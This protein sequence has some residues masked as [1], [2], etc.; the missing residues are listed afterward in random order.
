M[1]GVCAVI[2]VTTLKACQ[3]FGK[4]LTA[5]NACL[6]TFCYV[7]VHVHVHVRAHCNM[8]NYTGMAVPSCT[9]SIVAYKVMHTCMK[10]GTLYMYV[11]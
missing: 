5:L 8:Y 9:Y 4:W 10:K 11:V 1:A 7:H 3:L 6:P 2:V